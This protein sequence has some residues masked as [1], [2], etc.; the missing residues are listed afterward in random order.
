[1]KTATPESRSDD[2]G[3]GQERRVVP[4]PD[5]KSQ[6]RF[7]DGPLNGVARSP[8]SVMIELVECDAGLARQVDQRSGE[9]AEREDDQQCR[10]ALVTDLVRNIAPILTPEQSERYCT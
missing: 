7:H 1:M 9:E 4:E 2:D 10:A 3:E 5:V 8:S 6:Q